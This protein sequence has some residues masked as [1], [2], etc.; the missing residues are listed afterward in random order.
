MNMNDEASFG[1]QG[2]WSVAMRCQ[3]VKDAGLTVKKQGFEQI[4]RYYFN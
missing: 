1:L 4:K 3:R 2:L